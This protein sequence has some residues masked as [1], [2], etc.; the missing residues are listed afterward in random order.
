MPVL[1]PDYDSDPGRRRSWVAP[2]DIHDLV[3][4]EL[5]GPV[6]D[7]GCGEG[8]LVPTLVGGVEWVGIDSSPRQVAE[9]PYRPIVVGDMRALPFADDSFADVVQ[10]W[11]LYHL[12]DPRAAIAEA[13]RVL[14]DG[15]RYCACTASGYNDPEM[16]PEG[17][18]PTSFDAEDAV[19]IVASVFPN[20][21]PEAWDDVF[22]PLETRDEVRAYC[23][24]SFIP[25]ERAEAVELPLWLTK[26]G[27]LVR[28]T[29]N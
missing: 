2:R 6:L 12:A 5:E 27:V 9:C 8:R 23:R 21:E 4:S 1:E 24:H 20:A 7:I 14:R 28:A 16:M 3:G 29:K 13:R 17:Y 26:R 19:A 11:C 22:Y 18:P 15:G 25:I 10:L